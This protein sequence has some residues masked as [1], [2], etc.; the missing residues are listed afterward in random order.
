MA[1]S[2]SLESGHLLSY[3]LVSNG[4]PVP[5]TVQIVS[6]TTQ[7]AINRI[8]S[9][10]IVLLDGDMPGDSF[11]VSDSDLFKPGA[12]IVIEAGYDERTEVIFKGL[13]IRHGLKISG[14]NYARLVIE[15]R[16]KAVAMT[17]GRKNA[18]Y[19]DQT[20]SDIFAKLLGNYG[21]VTSDVSATA[22]QHKELVQHYCTDWDFLVS[23]AEV[24]GMLVIVDQNK[25]TVQ[26]PQTSGDA[27]LK[28]TYGVELM[29][30]HA[31]IDSRSQLK[32]VTSATWDPAA[33]AIVEK[34]AAP[35]QLNRQGDL[36]SSVLAQVGS[37]N[38]FRLQTPSPMEQTALQAWADSQQIKAGLAR[39]RGRMKFQGDVKA[40]AG[41][42]IELVGV[43]NRFSGVVFVSAVTHEL[44]DGDW[45]TEAEFGMPPQWFAEQRDLAAPPAAGLTPGIEGLHLG[46]VKKLDA[47]P[48]GEKKVQVS[49]PLLKA[50]ADG[51][52][53]RLANFYASNGFGDFFIPE[54]GD[55][56]VLGYLNDDPSHPVILGS[57]YSSK[58]AP[59]YELTAENYTKAI[60]TRSL[61]RLIF[62][63]EKKVV[64]IITPAG[65]KIVV[66]DDAK[67]ILLEDQN[68]NK[69]ELSPTGI[70][71]D[72]PKDITINAKGKITMSAVGEISVTAQADV[73][74]TGLNVTNTA[75]VG[76]TAKG[77]ATAE[78]SA[79]GQT[80]VKGALVMIN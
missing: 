12:E 42:L 49:I 11:P 53:A 56:V 2:P 25:V 5:D 43:G 16:D 78:L 57:L 24:N 70:L 1:E 76:Y 22:I 15:C 71:L 52:W 77:N 47:D 55:E 66:S 80:T 9:A 10:E 38:S 50:D 74:V 44:V 36:S 39:I 62:D 63:D 60:V 28:V 33:Q 4:A 79:A 75:Q 30:F 20:D 17:I 51:V 14:D 61:L 31:D 48:N 23:R 6:I 64:T 68:A 41:Q 21:G 65:N 27:S 46:V 69:A 13:V 7:S 67:S 29:E 34:T 73:S 40:K 18:N 19:V 8:P 58:R 26:P 37:P 35:K 45:T 54:I 32:S 72:S 59:P 3:K